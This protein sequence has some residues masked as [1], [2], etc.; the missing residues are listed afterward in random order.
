MISSVK[1]AFQQLAANP[2]KLFVKV[3]AH[4]SMSVELYRP[5]KTDP[6]TPHL[7]DEL[8]IIISGTGQ[9]FN[10]G[11]LSPFGPGDV[12]F[13]AAGKE[14]RFIN[15]TDDFA[16]WVVFYGAEGGESA[17]RES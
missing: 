4:G 10:D 12:L 7:Q 1:D 8:Y 16:T 14:H 9:F 3:M 15:F 17:S 11:T 2:G 13:V 6:Q 5:V